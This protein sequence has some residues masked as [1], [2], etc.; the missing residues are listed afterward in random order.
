[1]ITLSSRNLVAVKLL[2]LSMFL[3]LIYSVGSRSENIEIHVELSERVS[4]DILLPLSLL[5][6]NSF[7]LRA[8]PFNSEV[9]W[10]IND[11]K[12]NPKL[13]NNHSYGISISMPSRLLWEEFF[14]EFKALDGFNEFSKVFGI[15][16]KCLIGNN[17]LNDGLVIIYMFIEYKGVLY[18]ISGSQAFVF[19]NVSSSICHN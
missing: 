4:K 9:Y 5:D 11:S 16:G 10:L 17:L 14:K 13:E 6:N 3:L 7:S 1:M 18:M 8:H 15:D 19:E 2:F 12:F